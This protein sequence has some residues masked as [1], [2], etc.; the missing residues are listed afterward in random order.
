ML[1]SSLNHDNIVKIYGS[2]QS[3]NEGYFI[4]VS[5][6]EETLRCRLR[7]W[8]IAK[9]T[10]VLDQL[11]STA[12]GIAKGMEY[13]HDNNIVHRDLKARN[14]G[15]DKVTGPVILDFG[16]AAKIHSGRQLK[17]TV[18]TIRYLSPEV[19]LGVGYSF[20]CDVYSFGIILWQIVA[21]PETQFAYRCKTR[22]DLLEW[23]AKRGGRPSLKN[24]HCPKSANR[25]IK[26]CWHPDPTFRPT[27]TTIRRR[28]EMIIS[29]KP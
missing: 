18:G 6:L 23:V 25:L 20:P 21:L 7:K 9:H 17:S 15:Y 19:I 26:E 29:S 10:S 28:L 11:E 13:L 12:L 16:L 3:F 27:F 1:L 4:V 5:L 8:R 24:V 22:A 14:I 2:S